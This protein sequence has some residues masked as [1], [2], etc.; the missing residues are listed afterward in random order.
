MLER[1]WRNAVA[2]RTLWLRFLVSL[3]AAVLATFS[4]PKLAEA[5]LVVKRIVVHGKT[6]TTVRALTARMTLQTGDVVD[7]ASLAGAE[8][9]LVESDLFTSARVYVDLPT[10][11]AA[12]HMYVD[13]NVYG[14][15]VHV[16]VTDKQSWFVVPTGSFGSGDYAGGVAYGDQNLLGHDVTLI[17]AAQYGV[18]RSYG[19]VGF[20]VPV[21]VGAPLTW[22]VAGIVRSEQVRFFVDHKLVLQVPTFIAGGAGEFGWVLSPHLRAL[23]GVSART[24]RVG[25]PEVIEAD[26]AQPAFNP[27]SGRVFLLVFQVSY[28]NT[29]SPGGMR[30][31]TRLLLKNEL[32]DRYWGSQF[33][34]SKFE[35]RTELFGKLAW[36]Y[37]S[38]I[39]QTVFNFPTSARGVPI[40]ET[41]RIGGADLRGYLVDEF[42]GDTLVRTQL[43]D[44]VVV[45]RNLPVPFVE[46]RFHVAAAAFV[47]AAAL[48]ERH[49]GGT[50]VDLPNPA[51]PKLAD[52][53]TSVGTGF[54]VILPGVAI[55]AIKADFGYG[56]DVR[57]FAFTIS[58][59]GGS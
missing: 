29:T 8:K 39:L 15:D 59:A 3:V 36:N 45:L 43:E 35:V 52:F 19:F 33:D 1:I 27:R 18:S 32:S 54:R 57:S 55:P 37:P 56:I 12:H 26:A 50:A 34:Y 6:K 9:R 2:T 58:I 49:P 22:G 17:A 23:L 51:R 13:P 7:F 48:L 53:H 21:V 11:K 46:K 30:R 5:R 25:G 16:E 41:L 4:L 14:V 10:D 42:H 44:Q 24:Q 40:T 28:D 38:L 31:G 47:D 20:R